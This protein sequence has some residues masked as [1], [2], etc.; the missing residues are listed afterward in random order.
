MKH[1]KRSLYYILRE[2]GDIVVIVIVIVE[3]ILSLING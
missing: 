1:E 3:F 2:S